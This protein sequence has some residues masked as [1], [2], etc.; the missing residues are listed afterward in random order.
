M[1]SKEKL[2][3]ELVSRCPGV[4]RK[5][6]SLPYTSVNGHMFSQLNKEGQLGIRFSK[7]VQQQYIR[8]LNTTS[9]RSYGKEMQ[10]YV[11]MPE[12]LWDELNTLTKYLKES[13]DYV[14]SLDPK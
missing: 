8:E 1:K 4:E 11:L 13:F 12:H 7:T 9:F 14:S 6:K 2:Y 5:G 3:D 10:G